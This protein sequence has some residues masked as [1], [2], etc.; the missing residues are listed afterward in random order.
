VCLAVFTTEAPRQR[1]SEYAAL[2]GDMKQMELRGNQ[3]GFLYFFII[4]FK[5]DDTF[6]DSTITLEQRWARNVYNSLE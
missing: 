1:A 5:Y 3:L 4:S 6:K 2:L